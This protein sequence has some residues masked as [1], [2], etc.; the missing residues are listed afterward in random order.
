[1]KL[2]K[3]Y[4]KDCTEQEVIAIRLT[5]AIA[6]ARCDVVGYIVYGEWS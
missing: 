4:L 5:Q 6:A 2:F 3:L 1:M